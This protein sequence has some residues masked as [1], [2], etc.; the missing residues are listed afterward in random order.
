MIPSIT[1]PNRSIP[2]VFASRVYDIIAYCQTRDN[3]KQNELYCV[4]C[5][6]ASNYDRDLADALILPYQPEEIHIDEQALKSD[7]LTIFLP[8]RGSLSEHIRRVCTKYEF[9]SGRILLY[10]FDGLT[11]S[12][13]SEYKREISY[14]GDSYEFIFPVYWEKLINEED[15]PNSIILSKFFL[16]DKSIDTL[17]LLE[18][19][20]TSGKKYVYWNATAP[21]LEERAWVTYLY[22]K[23]GLYSNLGP[24]ISNT[25]NELHFNYY[26]GH[27][28]LDERLYYLELLPKFCSFVHPIFYESTTCVIIEEKREPEIVACY[29]YLTRVP[30]PLPEALPR[31]ADIVPWRT[32]FPYKKEVPAINYYPQADCYSDYIGNDYTKMDGYDFNRQL[33]DCFIEC[34][35]TK[36]INIRNTILTK[37]NRLIVT[38]GDTSLVVRMLTAGLCESCESF[39]I[40]EDMFFRLQPLPTG[41]YPGMPIMPIPR[42]YPLEEILLA[43]TGGKYMSFYSKSLRYCNAV[44][45]MNSDGKSLFDF[46]SIRQFREDITPPVVEHPKTVKERDNALIQAPLNNRYFISSFGYPLLPNADKLPITCS[47][48]ILKDQII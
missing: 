34:D 45:K 48:N 1:C 14:M 11:P 17:G 4:L 28:S 6:E 38:R 24:L 42:A 22:L 33:I 3:Y 30:L 16:P 25:I 9:N 46:I 39:Q 19:V 37:D 41:V 20:K 21:T 44:D 8:V 27:M 7:Y 32:L 15:Y 35:A 10:A 12:L 29:D 18:A 47:I 43:A 23:F 36:D 40:T 31:Y 13:V 26:K 5:D 2:M